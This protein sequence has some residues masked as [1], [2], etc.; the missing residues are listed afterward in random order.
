MFNQY[1]RE[2]LIQNKLNVKRHFCFPP[3]A[4]NGRPE[5]GPPGEGEERAGGTGGWRHGREYLHLLCSP[6]VS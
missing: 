4:E 3:K 6:D 1:L 5:V 2:T